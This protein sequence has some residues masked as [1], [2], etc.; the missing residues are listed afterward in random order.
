MSTTTREALISGDYFE[1]AS[2]VGLELGA[3]DLSR[4]EFQSCTFRG[5]K[6]P[7]SQWLGTLLEDCTF[8][9]CDLTNML[10]RGLVA[11]DVRFAE[12]K[13]LG[14]D[15]ANAAPHPRLAF[16]ACDLRYAAFSAMHLRK[17]PFLRSQ[18][19]EAT[20]VDVDLTESD[21]DGSDLAGTSFRECQLQKVDFSGA[22]GLLLD[23]TKNRVKDARVSLEAAAL[24]AA[25]FGLRVAGYGEREPAQRA[26][27][28][29]ST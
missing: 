7:A 3:I 19:T 24:L 16:E 22:R 2:F 8:E 17:T 25:S 20:F 9:L 27:G 11:R 26:R 23:P 4:K 10:P 15:W 12:C 1:S 28:R 13:L 14:V 5:V 18:I 6:L 21:F 29:R